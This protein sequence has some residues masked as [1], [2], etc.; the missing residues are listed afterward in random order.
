[1]SSGWPAGPAGSGRVV[2]VGAINVDLV[3]AAGRLPGPGE[4]VVGARVERH[5]GGKGANAAVAAAR[6]GAAVRLVGAVG[7]G[8]GCR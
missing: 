5:G 2:V 4:T 8:G 3:V 6:A 1:M 7:A